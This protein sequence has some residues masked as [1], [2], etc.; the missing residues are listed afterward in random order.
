MKDPKYTLVVFGATSFVGQLL[1]RYL[2]DEFG[3][4]LSWA[5]A[6]RSKSKLEQLRND[7]GVKAANLPLIVAESFDE[8]SLHAMCDQTGVIVSTVG[9]YALYGEQL[10][11]VCAE[12]GTDY[13][14]LTGE[15]QW[16][17]AMIR[18][19][20]TTA[21][22]SGARIVHCCGFD[23]LPSDLGVHYLQQEAH[24]RFGQP[25]TRV[26]LRIKA[27][28]GGVSGGTI[29]SM[30]NIV[31]QAAA[32]PA[33][34]KELANPYSL[35]P[36]D[37]GFSKRQKDVNGASYDADFKTWIAPFVMAGINTRVVHRS[38]HLSGKAYGADFVYDEASMTR[39][40]VKGSAVA[41]GVALGIGGFMLAAA[42]GPVRGLMARHM[43]PKPGEG[44]SPA[45]QLK[46]Y[47]D[48]RF[49]GTT[50]D[51][52]QLRVK[53][54]GDR[55]PGYGSTAKM[56]GQA[57]VCLARDVDGKAGGFW[58]PATLFG[59]KLVA[60]LVAHAG[61]TFSVLDDAAAPK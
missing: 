29:A 23:S 32:N 59:E 6:G 2:L 52:R 61:L 25:C 10:V 47:Y 33:L 58:T 41:H 13:C 26:K 20:E 39:K 1:C 18:R 21:R 37:H 11:K 12:G 60:R 15:V 44:P 5:A 31:E 43:L 14:D 57:A 3:D 53:V 54:T 17:G 38:N 16:V 34:R 7:L 8:E 48:F 9:P 46:G 22:A 24:K 51:G 30:L 56:L 36:A 4:S 27:M 45:A 19:Y 49:L 28:K 42:V 40:G 50:A 35:C 55:D